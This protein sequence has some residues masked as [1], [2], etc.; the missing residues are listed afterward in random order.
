MTDVGGIPAYVDQEYVYRQIYYDVS[1][2]A[3]YPFS[4]FQRVEVTGGYTYLDFQNTVYTTVTSAVDGS[5]IS[6]DATD[7]PSAKG[8]HMP[9][10]AAALVYDS[11]LFGATAPIL[12]QSYRFEVTPT[13]GTLNF[14]TVLADIRKYIVPIRPITLAFRL[15]HYGRYGGGADDPRFYPL[16][17]GYDML[18]RGYN[19]ES[20]N[21]NESFDINRLFGSKMALANVEM[22]F[23]L[24]GILGIGKGYY[25]IFPVDFLAFYDAGFV[26]GKDMDG[27]D[28]SFNE[29][30]KKPLTSAGIGLRVNV[31]G[32]LVL[33]VDYVVPFARP[34]KG[35]YFQFSFYP[36][37]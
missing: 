22:R 6:Y 21:A 34:E 35:P 26:W 4:Q 1:A 14:T 3:S 31:M 20:F 9:H 28:H 32:Y 11:S 15:T 10:V 7:I 29:G 5:T 12:G 17:L 30:F 16:Y 27:V 13:F 24:F 2:F 37:F 36:G 19:Y 33:G 18:L 23:P 8:L 25:G